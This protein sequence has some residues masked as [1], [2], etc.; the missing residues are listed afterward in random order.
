M[1]A[2]GSLAMIAGHCPVP[3]L[4]ILWSPAS[5]SSLAD[6]RFNHHCHNDSTRS[7]RIKRFCPRLYR[8]AP[9]RCTGL[10]AQQSFALAYHPR[11]G[12]AHT[13]LSHPE[14]IAAMG[15]IRQTQLACRHIASRA[16]TCGCEWAGPELA[17]CTLCT[18][19]TSLPAGSQVSQGEH[20]LHHASQKY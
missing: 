2:M 13:I 16:E 5:I 15:T 4:E 7:F 12:R 8:P 1:G 20:W 10:R 9:S 6:P 18:C 19:I 11:N 14:N 17:G 3:T